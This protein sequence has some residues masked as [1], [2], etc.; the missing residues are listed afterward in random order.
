MSGKRITMQQVR[1]YMNSKSQG[2]TQA[3]AGA[4]AGVSERS[5][6]VGEAAGVGRH[7]PV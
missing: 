4:K 2:A 6:A 5:C 7:D 1:L 3:Q